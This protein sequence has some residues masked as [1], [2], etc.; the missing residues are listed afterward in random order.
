MS[1]DTLE[2]FRPQFGAERMLRAL[3]QVGDMAPH[4]QVQSLREILEY[5]DSGDVG[6][7]RALIQHARARRNALRV[8]L[9][10]PV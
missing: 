3:L 10:D 2:F 1:E 4:D 5:I 9:A 8:E 6:A 7:A